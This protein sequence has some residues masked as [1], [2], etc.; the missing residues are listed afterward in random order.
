MIPI[1][2]KSAFVSVYGMEDTIIA[3]LH[4]CRCDKDGPASF[5]RSRPRHQYSPRKWKFGWK[6]LWEA[7][8]WSEIWVGGGSHG[9]L[10]RA[11]ARVFL[12][13]SVAFTLALRVSSVRS[14]KCL[15]HVKPF[16]ITDFNYSRCFSLHA[17]IQGLFNA[18]E[19]DITWTFDVPFDRE[20]GSSV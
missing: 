7:K 1:V 9:A 13:L 10:S 12:L 18:Q 3:L 11:K 15:L 2:T 17:F 20:T 14:S 5:P 19:P 8:K 4:I 6:A 16:G